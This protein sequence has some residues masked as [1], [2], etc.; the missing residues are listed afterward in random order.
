[1]NTKSRDYNNYGPSLRAYSLLLLRRII[2][3]NLKLTNVTFSKS[4]SQSMEYIMSSR[5][6]ILMTIYANKWDTWKQHE[7]QDTT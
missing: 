4:N 7:H 5:A 2:L 1:M 3:K 6:I